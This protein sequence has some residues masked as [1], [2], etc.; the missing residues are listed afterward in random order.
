MSNEREADRI[1]EQAKDAFTAKVRNRAFEAQLIWVDQSDRVPQQAWKFL[2]SG[3][4]SEFYDLVDESYEDMRWDAAEEKAQ[5][6]LEGYYPWMKDN[7]P[8]HVDDLRNFILDQD[9]SNPS[10]ELLQKAGRIPVH[11]NLDKTNPVDYFQLE[12][13]DIVSEV[14]SK[15]GLRLTSGERKALEEAWAESPYSGFVQL[16]GWVEPQA[17]F[18]AFKTEASHLVVANAFLGF[19]DPYNGSGSFYE[20]ASTRVVELTSDTCSHDADWDWNW[21]R[22]AGPYWPAYRCEVQPVS[23]L[24]SEKEEVKLVALDLMSQGIRPDQAVLAAREATGVVKLS[25]RGRGTRK[26]IAP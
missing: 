11:F 15:L 8:E 18:A 12:G 17:I 2:L 7:Y 4:L 9:T 26:S 16:L 5:E 13:D 14:A 21:D 25:A 6:M 3:N 22:I 1:L 10:E 23:F 19:F 20:T 24:K